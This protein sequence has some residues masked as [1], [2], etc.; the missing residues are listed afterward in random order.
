[1]IS[2]YGEPPQPLF[3]PRWND[4][5]YKNLG[6]SNEYKL[7]IEKVSK[8][9]NQEFVMYILSNRLSINDSK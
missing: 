1:M 4:E 8:L 3:I 9:N 6:R 2:G 5:D 7:F